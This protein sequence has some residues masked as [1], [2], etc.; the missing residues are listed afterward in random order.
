M[1]T[2]PKRI[3]TVGLG[4]LAVVAM[5]MSIVRMATSDPTLARGDAVELPTTAPRRSPRPSS[6][7][8]DASRSASS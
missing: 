5:G 8:W 3:L 1:K 2:T 6:R 4:I 7:C